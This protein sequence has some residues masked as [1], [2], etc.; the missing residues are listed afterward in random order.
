MKSIEKLSKVIEKLALIPEEHA[1]IRRECAMLLGEFISDNTETKK[2]GALTVNDF[3]SKDELRPAMMHVFHDN[4]AGVAVATDAHVLFANPDEYIEPSQEECSKYD[5]VCGSNLSSTSYH[6]IVRNTYGV[7][8]EFEKYPNWRSVIPSKGY[9]SLPIR[10]DLHEVVKRVDSIK[11][12]NSIKKKDSD[13]MVNV[14]TDKGH[15]VWINRDYIKH[16][17]NA[18]VDG[19]ECRDERSWASGIVKK[20]DN[21]RILLIMPMCPNDDFEC[22][23]P[24]DDE[25]VCPKEHRELGILFKNWKYLF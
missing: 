22:G 2:K 4:V 24:V 12:I 25:H 21:G 20:W 6:G 17:V 16:I 19:W 10:E 15:P 8:Q 14:S 23:F 3:V 11:K 18:G 7:P 1:Q 13:C 5:A 9:T